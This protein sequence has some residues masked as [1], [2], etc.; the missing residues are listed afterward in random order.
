MAGSMWRCCPGSYKDQVDV[1]SYLVDTVQS[2]DP[3]WVGLSLIPPANLL[4]SGG[5][6]AAGNHGAGAGGAGLATRL[7]A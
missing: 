7:E 2:L 5:S 4:S 1:T 3:I 6:C